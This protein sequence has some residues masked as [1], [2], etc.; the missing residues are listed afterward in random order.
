M[1]YDIMIGS[2]SSD[3]TQTVDN[4]NNPLIENSAIQQRI[5]IAK[6]FDPK[7][8]YIK[9]LGSTVGSNEDNEDLHYTISNYEFNNG[10]RL[11]RNMN[12]MG[13]LMISNKKS[14]QNSFVYLTINNNDGYE[15]V[16]YKTLGVEI[17]NTYKKKE[18]YQGC[19]IKFNP[20]DITADFEESDIPFFKAEVLIGDS[21]HNV[22]LVYDKESD[23][24]LVIFS[25]T[26]SY[27]DVF[28]ETHTERKFLQFRI[29]DTEGF[30]TN[31]I[32]TSSSD[33]SKIRNIVKDIRIGSPEVI[34]LYPEDI[35][36][37]ENDTST[38]RLDDI[39][40][41]YITSKRTKA[42]TVYNLKLSKEFLKKH[43]ILYLFKYDD[44]E[45]RSYVL[46][47][48]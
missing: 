10:T 19:L 34:E 41:E 28:V 23:D 9:K 36:A 15:L 16:N 33:A 32:F 18:K 11:V 39:V 7:S 48:T 8:S 46:R 12:N 30:A 35:A 26:G 24:V 43:G 13:M 3:W 17:I 27:Y 4:Y 2:G 45:G 37:I 5:R 1:L 42:V 22:E 6:N 21:L 29:S 25:D 31:A 20:T 44:R 40:L 14:D 47:S 38:Q